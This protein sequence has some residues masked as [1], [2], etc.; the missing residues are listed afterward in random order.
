M[1]NLS[2]RFK[3]RHILVKK[4]FQ[5]ATAWA[6][7]ENTEFYWNL[8]NAFGSKTSPRLRKVY[9]TLLIPEGVSS[10][11]L[12]SALRTIGVSLGGGR[13]SRLRRRGGVSNKPNL[14]R[15][16]KLHSSARRS[17]RHS[18]FHRS[19][20]AF[21]HPHESRS[22]TSPASTTRFPSYVPSREYIRRWYIM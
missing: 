11:V 2:P 4:V 19:F 17:I 5:F 3:S 13:Q 16:I 1:T 8:P 10:E 20:E 12:V 9:D 15:P 22:P 6:K 21:L 14:T 18:H 7:H